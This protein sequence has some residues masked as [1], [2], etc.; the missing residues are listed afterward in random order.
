MPTYLY[1]HTNH[2]PIPTP[3]SMEAKI[4]KS[5][6]APASTVLEQ[7]FIFKTSVHREQNF[8]IYISSIIHS[9]YDSN[10]TPY[11]GAKPRPFP[12]KIK[13]VHV[14]IDND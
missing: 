14:S 9:G 8:Q 3:T 1:P 5:I 10:P 6:L 4:F 2:I 12:T 7:L 11:Q 13:Q